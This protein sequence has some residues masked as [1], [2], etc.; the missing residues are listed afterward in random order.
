MTTSAAAFAE[1]YRFLN[2]SNPATTEVVPQPPGRVTVSGRA[3]YFPSNAGAAGSTLRVYRVFAATGQRKSAVPD[4]QVPIGPDGSFGPLHINGQAHYEFAVTLPTGITQHV[5]FQPFERSDHFV[6][7]LVSP[8]G[9]IDS[10]ITRDPGRMAIT[11]LRMREWRADQ[12]TAAEND[13]LL[14]NGAD[15]LTPV[16]DPR[17]RD[18]ISLFLFDVGNDGITNLN[19]LVFPFN[20]TKFLTNVDIYIPASADHSGTVSLTNVGRQTGAVTVPQK[21]T[22][23]VPDWPSSTDGVTVQFKEYVPLSFSSGHSS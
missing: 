20:V 14:V 9:G 1:L 2:G 12:P 3:D 4:Y 10:F 13:Q 23:N 8:P 15:V 17:S 11:V 21:A 5:Y 7:L 6:R 22:I 16:N 19:N 18:V